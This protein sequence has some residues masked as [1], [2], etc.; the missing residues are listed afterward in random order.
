MG[1]AYLAVAERGDLE[2]AHTEVML[3]KDVENAGGNDPLFSSSSSS[4]SRS[5]LSSISPSPVFAPLEGAMDAK[6]VSVRE[7]FFSPDGHLSLHARV[8]PTNDQQ[9]PFCWVGH[10]EEDEEM[11]D[12]GTRP[13]CF[14][15]AWERL[16]PGKVLAHTCSHNLRIK[17]SFFDLDKTLHTHS[18]PPQQNTTTTTTTL[19]TMANTSAS[20]TKRIPAF[21]AGLEKLRDPNVLNTC[22]GLV[23]D[24]SGF[25]LLYINM[26]WKSI[27]MD[28]ASNMPVAN[29]VKNKD[30]AG[31][32]LWVDSPCVNKANALLDTW[33]F[34]FH[35]V[36]HVT[37]YANP[38]ITPT[39]TPVALRKKP[40]RQRPRTMA[41]TQRRQRTRPVK[42]RR[43]TLVRASYPMAGR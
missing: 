37:S 6:V 10:E 8:G 35:S 40:R 38:P 42:S 9:P 5:P 14:R 26:P 12:R 29:L 1:H 25:D 20:T 18:T 34:T 27:S 21:Q 2:A 11:M 16:S 24:M 22:N 43:R 33:G 30:H 13:A 17:S 15:F 36:L 32:L 39:A 23:T 3:A 31:L 4:S 19:Q 7:A 28:Y 41:W